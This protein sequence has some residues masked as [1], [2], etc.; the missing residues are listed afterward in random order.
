MPTL[1]WS[2]QNKSIFMNTCLALYKNQNISFVFYLSLFSA[3]IFFILPK[4]SYNLNSIFSFMH[5]YHIYSLQKIGLA[6]ILILLK[7]CVVHLLLDQFSLSQENYWALIPIC[8]FPR[9]RL[10][11]IPIFFI[12][13]I[14]IEYWYHFISSQ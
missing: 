6:I 13:K 4:S 9:K 5:W 14:I 8:I 3:L 1:L 11:L 2:N 10:T 7:K 12:S